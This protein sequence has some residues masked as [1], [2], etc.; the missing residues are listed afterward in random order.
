[1]KKIR[2]YCNFFKQA[3]G[4]VGWKKK[5]LIRNNT[6]GTHLLQPTASCPTLPF[7]DHRGGSSC[8]WGKRPV[9]KQERKARR[10]PPC[11]KWSGGRCIPSWLTSTRVPPQSA[12]TEREEHLEKYGTDKTVVAGAFQH[13]QCILW[14]RMMLLMSWFDHRQAGLGL[15]HQYFTHVAGDSEYRQSVAGEQSAHSPSRCCQ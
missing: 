12:G 5:I 6:L 2:V 11:G 15:H 14:I 8:P 10:W 1:M 4:L 3:N 7:W 9:S 13:M